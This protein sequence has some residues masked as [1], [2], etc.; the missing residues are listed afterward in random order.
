MDAKVEIKQ[1]PE[2]SV[3]YYRHTRSFE[4]ISKTYKKLYKWAI[5]RGLITVS[6]RNI[7]VYLDD[8]SITFIDNYVKIQVSL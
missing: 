3:V 2:L 4:K 8:P 6:T 7:T 1:M 5:I